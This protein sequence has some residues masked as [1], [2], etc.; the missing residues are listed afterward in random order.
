MD[1]F[2]PMYAIFELKKYRGV[3][4]HNTEECYKT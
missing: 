3:M 2:C 4:C 1:P